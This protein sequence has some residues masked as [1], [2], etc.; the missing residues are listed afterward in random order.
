MCM[1]HGKKAKNDKKQQQKIARDLESPGI[2]SAGF[3]NEH[4]HWVLPSSR[5]KKVLLIDFYYR[6]V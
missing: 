2:V 3:E 4:A 6:S 5:Y 1:L